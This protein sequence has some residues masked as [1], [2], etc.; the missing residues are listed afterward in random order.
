MFKQLVLLTLTFGA[1]AAAAK[2]LAERRQTRQRK[3]DS[4]AVQRWEDEGGAVEPKPATTASAGV[5]EH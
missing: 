2:K 3:R 1:T 4:H 5:V